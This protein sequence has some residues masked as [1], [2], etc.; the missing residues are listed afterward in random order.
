MSVGSGA[1][2]KLLSDVAANMNCSAKGYRLFWALHSGEALHHGTHVAG[3][4]SRSLM[5]VLAFSQ[6]L[7]REVMRVVKTHIAERGPP[8]S[9]AAKK[10]VF[11]ISMFLFEV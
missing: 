11:F 3:K 4:N 2:R 9:I 8:Y 6:T 10:M 5:L 7:D 1:T